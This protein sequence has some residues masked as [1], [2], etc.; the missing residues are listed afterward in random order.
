VFSELT[1][2]N[3]VYLGIYNPKLI[4]T[5]IIDIF[6]FLRDLGAYKGPKEQFSFDYLL[7]PIK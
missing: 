6:G 3:C 2:R 7:Y 1:I 4:G 5:K